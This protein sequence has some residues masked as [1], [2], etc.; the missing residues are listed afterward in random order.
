MSRTEDLVST[1]IALTKINDTAF[2]PR[3]CKMIP[4]FSITELEEL[5]NYLAHENPVYLEHIYQSLTNEQALCIIL[6]S[7]GRSKQQE[8]DQHHILP[9]ST[10]NPTML[11][12]ICE[13]DQFSLPFF[14]QHFFDRY[15]ALYVNDLPIE[16]LIMESNTNEIESRPTKRRKTV[17]KYDLFPILHI[18]VH[19][20]KHISQLLLIRLLSI[21]SSNADLVRDFAELMEVSLVS[22]VFFS[23]LEEFSDR[24][25]ELSEPVSVLYA[26]LAEQNK[27]LAARL[28]HA[29][30]TVFVPTMSIYDAVGA[31]SE[32]TVEKIMMSSTSEVN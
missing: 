6:V 16:H 15:L 25:Q 19:S 31:T 22:E 12:K 9:Y 17:R 28:C 20:R 1:F 26:T 21:M 2:E 3:I 8:L 29:L 7:A 10:S 32:A 18:F 14:F 4:Q 23:C 5:I 13:I 30:P 27:S 24:K 11:D